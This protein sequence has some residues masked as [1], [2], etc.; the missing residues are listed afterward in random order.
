MIAG[1]LYQRV[2]SDIKKN[3]LSGKYEVGTLIPTENELEKMYKVSKITIRKAVELL[4]GEGYL[5]KKSGIG[6]TVIS[7]NLFN[8]LSKA[9]SF[10]SI[11]DEN[12][13]L[14]KKILEIKLVPP[15]GTPFENDINQHILYI[16]RLYSLNDKPFIV[17][18]HYLPNVAIQEELKNLR[19]KSL[20]KIL[21][22]SGHE[23]ASFKDE[24]K[25][26]NLDSANQQLLEKSDTLAIKRI[27]RG[28]DRFDNLIE[29]SLAMYDTN[30]F[31]YEIEYEV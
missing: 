13:S 18:E 10:S 23:I 22:E 5:V 11:V 2:A 30:K 4:V 7:N 16:K 3:I 25:A 1:S 9:R 28:F 29:Y 14:T 6:T 19:H 8:K 12:G 15:T 24:F 26:V 17:F 31:P 21:Q 27:R 20:Y